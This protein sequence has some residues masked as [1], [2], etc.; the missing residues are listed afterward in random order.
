LIGLAGLIELRVASSLFLRMAS[1][2]DRQVIQSTTG[3]R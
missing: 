2:Y 1:D 3:L